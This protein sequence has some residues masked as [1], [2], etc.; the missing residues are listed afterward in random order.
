M[1]YPHSPALAPLWH[2]KLVVVS[3]REPYAVRL[4]Q[5]TLTIH[6][7][8]GGLVSALDPVLQQSNG[9]WICWSGEAWPQSPPVAY[10][11]LVRL[12]QHSQRAVSYAI[13][14]VALT[15]EEVAAYYNGYANRQ[16]WPLFHYFCDRWVGQGEDWQHYYRVNQK[17][18]QAILHDSGPEAYVWIQD[19]HLLLVPELVRREDPRRKLG[20]FCHIP[21]PALE[22]FRM[23][24]RRV[25][26]LR[27]MLGS[28]LVGFHIPAYV[29]HFLD[30]VEALLGDEAQVDRLRGEI[31]FDKRRIRVGAFPIGV[32]FDTLTT[33]AQQADKSARKLRNSFHVECVGV[34]VDR[35]DYSKGILQ[36][37]EAIGLFCERYPAY[38]RRFTFIQIAVPSRS[39]I[40]EY[41]QMKAQL[42]ETVGRIN[43]R[44]GE[45]GW[46]PIQYHY[47]SLPIQKLIGYYQM[48]DFAMVT[49]L[50][51]G[52]NLVAKEYC[53]AQVHQKGVLILSELAGAAQQLK[54][55]LLVNPYDLDQLVV[56]MRQAMEMPYEEREQRMQA[57]RQTIAQTDI[58]WWVQQYL[59][60]FQEAVAH[61]SHYEWGARDE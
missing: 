56:A 35:L 37:L 42:E 28:D 43:G 51:D 50:R 3:N 12:A 14:T 38:R 46:V 24:P 9:L 61:R 4:E 39:A 32:D 6:K 18:A 30:C 22:V 47:R 16:L 8:M 40:P 33:L 60:A 21:F 41:Q 57:L 2:H 36:R 29:H 19:Y 45:G 27:G 49:P 55:A 17:F 48:A 54:A 15:P 1:P 7:T 58:H 31:L 13:Q 20:F 25:E 5:K 44:Y 23:L 34:G 11:D 59:R 26:L 53:A 10:S 52:M